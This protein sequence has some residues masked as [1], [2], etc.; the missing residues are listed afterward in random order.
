MGPTG[1][2]LYEGQLEGEH[3]GPKAFLLALPLLLAHMFQADVLF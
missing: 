3:A 2:M 1:G